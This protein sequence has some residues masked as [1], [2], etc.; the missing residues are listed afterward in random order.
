[1]PTLRALGLPV[2]GAAHLAM[3]GLRVSL[4]LRTQGEAPHVL[5][6]RLVSNGR[7]LATG[8]DA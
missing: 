6:V 2:A 3:R 4:A 8:F 5:A 7:I 1:M